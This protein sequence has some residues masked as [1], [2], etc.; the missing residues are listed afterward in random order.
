M[1]LGSEYHLFLRCTAK[2]EAKFGLAIGRHT[3]LSDFL[4]KLVPIHTGLFNVLF[5]VIR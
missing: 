1:E 5:H 2:G 4:L 3:S